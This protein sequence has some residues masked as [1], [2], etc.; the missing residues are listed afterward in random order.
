LYLIYLPPVSSSPLYIFPNLIYLSN[1]QVGGYLSGLYTVG[2]F[3]LHLQGSWEGLT[4]TLKEL[5]KRLQWS[6]VRLSKPSVDKSVLWR[7]IW[8]SWLD[9]Q[10]RK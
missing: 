1:N 5:S 9:L 8:V 4:I 7:K 2:T 10:K 3:P 6:C